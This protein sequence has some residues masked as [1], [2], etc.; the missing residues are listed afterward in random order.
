MALAEP[1]TDGVVAVV[2]TKKQSRYLADIVSLWIEE[3]ED[4]FTMTMEDPTFDDPEDMLRAVDGLR[5]Q[6]VDAVH[7]KELIDACNR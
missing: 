3:H 4:A 1:D 7:I 2:M 5:E 6:V